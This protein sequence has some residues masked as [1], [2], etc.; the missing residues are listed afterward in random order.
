V[1]V[2]V[3]FTAKRANLKPSTLLL[4]ILLKATKWTV[5]TYKA[6]NNSSN[7]NYYRRSDY[8]LQL[9]VNSVLVEKESIEFSRV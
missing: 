4:L 8:W 1:A 9:S 7:F 5:S 2:Y 3:G 6:T